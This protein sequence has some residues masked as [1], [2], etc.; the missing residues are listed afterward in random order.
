MDAHRAPSRSASRRIVE[1]QEDD[2]MNERQHR[3]VVLALVLGAIQ[4]VTG[5]AVLGLTALASGSLGS[6]LSR[7]RGLVVWQ[8]RCAGMAMIVLGIGLAARARS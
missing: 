3:H 1:I 5:F 2:S 4:K 7:H 6:W 8:Q